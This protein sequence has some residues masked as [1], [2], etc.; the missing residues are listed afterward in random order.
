MVAPQDRVAQQTSV[1][2]PSMNQKFSNIRRDRHKRDASTRRAQHGHQRTDKTTRRSQTVRRGRT[3]RSAPTRRNCFNERHQWRRKRIKHF[4]HHNRHEYAFQR[5]A[6]W[7][8]EWVCRE[9][10][11]SADRF[12][13]PVDIRRLPG[14]APSTMVKIKKSIPQNAVVT[15]GDG[16]P[17]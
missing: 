15:I 9:P 7:N 16:R 4:I 6:G 12:C 10:V 3:Q 1:A 5:D 11:I 14:R 13:K 2:E 8:V 17:T